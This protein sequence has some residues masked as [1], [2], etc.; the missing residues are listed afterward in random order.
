M[1]GNLSR[2]FPFTDLKFPMASNVSCMLE[3]ECPMG[4]FG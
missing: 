4:M 3:N 2:A 1:K